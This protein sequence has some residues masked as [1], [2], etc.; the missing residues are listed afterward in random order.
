[1]KLGT[2]FVCIGKRPPPRDNSY[3]SMFYVISYIFYLSTTV[4]PQLGEICFS[5]RYVPTTGKL[6]VIV[7]ECK[8]LKKMDVGGLSGKSW[9]VTQAK[10]GFF[11]RSL[12]Q[13][14]SHAEWQENPKE[15]DFNQE[16]HLEPILQRVALLRYSLRVH[17]V[18]HSSR[19][20]GRL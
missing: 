1:M 5:L 12:R 20:C 14:I 6:T 15:E 19:G 11:S 7:M 16:V 13:N 4:L 9:T 10:I 2:F 18:C 17:P 3:R 8:N